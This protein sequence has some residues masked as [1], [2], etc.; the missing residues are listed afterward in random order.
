MTKEQIINKL[1]E[2]FDINE[3]FARR[4]YSLVNKKEDL[5]SEAYQLISE[6][7]KPFVKWVGGKRQ[8]LSQFKLLN[9]YPETYL[10]PAGCFQP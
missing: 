1:V 10:F 8:L 5:M 9:L 4:V 2:A 7:P 3:I 6:K